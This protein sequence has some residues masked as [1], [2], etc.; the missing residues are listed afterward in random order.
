MSSSWQ[1]VFVGVTHA[2]KIEKGCAWWKSPCSSSILSG[3]SFF[4]LTLSA[5]T[6][7]VE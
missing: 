1:G 7:V 4:K 6:P 3:W 5:S 2:A